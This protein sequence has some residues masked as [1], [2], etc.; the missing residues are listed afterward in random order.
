MAGT[1][2]M[3]GKGHR[4]GSPASQHRRHGFLHR[5]ARDQRGNTM[6]IA[7]AAIFPLVGLVGGAL[8]MSRMYI[9][10]TKLQSA[11]DAGALTGR[12]VMGVGTWAANNGAANL[13]A[14]RIFDLNFENGAFGTTGRSRSFT[15]NA[16]LVTGTASVTVPMTLMKLFDMSSE[17]VN[18][19][20]EGVMRIPNTDVMFVLDTTGSMDATNTGDTAPKID[21]LKV[22]VKCFYEALVRNNID[23]VTPAQCGETVDPTPLISNQSQIRIGFVPYAVNV[24]VGKL[25]PHAYIADS[26]TYQSRQPFL[27]TVYTYV[28]GSNTDG[29]PSSW[30]PATPPSPWNVAAATGGYT[31]FT[32][33]ASNLNAT[34]PRHRN[35]VTNSTACANQNNLAGSG[36][37]LVLIDEVAGTTARTNPSFAA[38]VYNAASQSKTDT[39]TETGRITRAYRYR[40]LDPDGAGGAGNGCYLERSNNTGSYNR[41]RTIPVSRSLTWTTHN[42]KFRRWTYQSMT[43]NVAGLKHANGVT[44]NNSVS[45]PVGSTNVSLS[46]PSGQTSAQTWLTLANSNVSWSGCIEELPTWQNTDG[47][48]SNDWSPVPSEALD[49]DIDYVPSVLSP[50]R[51]RPALPTAVWG[52][53][54]GYTTDASGNIDPTEVF[55]P[56]TPAVGDPLEQYF[57]AFHAA[58]CPSPA[59]KLQTW[60]TASDATTYKTYINSLVTDGNTYHDI[61]MLWGA[62]LMWPTGIFGSENATTPLGASI[63]RNMIF[64]TDGDTVTTP[65][66]YTYHG[67]AWWDRRQ[68]ASATEP[69]TALLNSVV[70]ARTLALCDAIKN[71][72]ITLW[73]ISYGNTVGSATETRLESCASNGKFFRATSTASLITQFKSI[74]AEISELR[75]TT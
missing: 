14:Q 64:M 37:T 42:D 23:D 60:N 12:K 66:N 32:L 6:A 49:M 73:V 57:Q 11:C 18:V 53:Y 28:A 4:M 50:A 3:F 52:R 51:W 2:G 68:T 61:G 33:M 47:D 16:G 10:K 44:W 17:T 26:A 9:V 21:G 1:K 36:S 41:S 8:D 43:F 54:S 48:P 65:L 72:N 24:N 58:S 59:K 70:D 34:Y 46:I 39:E 63:Q 38:P 35:T 15:E 19:T 13:A 7:A 45:L 67:L 62:R 30:S 29:S 55:A 22:A 20:C 56:Y 27:E 71:Q 74:A 69:T 31:G 40:W 75:L 25:L 5:L